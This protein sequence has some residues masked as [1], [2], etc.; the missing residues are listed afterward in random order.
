MAGGTYL[1]QIP[2]ELDAIGGVSQVVRNL[3]IALRA[4]QEQRAAVLISDWSAARFQQRSHSLAPECEV[5]LFRYRLRAPLAAD[6]G[7]RS[8]LAF[9]ATA[10]ATVATLRRMLA[11]L[12]ARAVN[13]HY[14]GENAWIWVAMKRLRML[15]APL[16][17]SFHGQDLT[18]IEQAIGP[19]RSVWNDLLRSADA[20]V[21]CSTS[22]RDR[23]TRSVP[24]CPVPRFVVYNGCDPQAIRA[25]ATQ[26]APPL[27][28][29]AGRRYLLSLGTFERKKGHDVLIDAFARMAPRHDDLDLVIAGR[30]ADQE[31]IDALRAQSAAH[32]LGE[33]VRLLMDV[34]HGPAMRLLRDA[35]LLAVPSRIEPFGIVALEAG[36]LARPVV[37]SDACGV[38]EAIPADTLMRFRSGDSAELAELISR[39]LDRPEAG[40]AAAERL[41]EFVTTNLTWRAAVGGGGCGVGGWWCGGGYVVVLG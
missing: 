20:L 8:A 37:V 35:A 27:P 19:H 23:L 9:A 3:A 32:G 39:A 12:D 28:P 16:V 7:I 10:P 13:V 5:E 6:S 26:H 36:A 1:L 25:A 21:F 11:R 18:G 24:D 22:L 2:W 29:V 40:Q 14:P 30:S 34:P 15:R 17:L 41:Q 31:C 38:C 4:S 33:R